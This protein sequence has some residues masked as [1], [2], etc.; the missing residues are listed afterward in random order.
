VAFADLM[1]VGDRS[2]RGILGESI[3]YTPGASAGVVVSGI[4]SE[5]YTRVDPGGNPGVS[6]TGPAVFLTLAD[7]P[8]DPRT[9]IAARVTVGGVV[10]AIHEVQPDGLGAVHLLLHRA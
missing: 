7:L 6:S 8:S 2:V 9:D 10:Y 1:A 5:Q 3:T 4:F